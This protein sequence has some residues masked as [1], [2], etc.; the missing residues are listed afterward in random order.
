MSS[1]S[2]LLLNVH[3]NV[4]VL[5]MKLNY[6]EPKIYNGGLDK[7]QWSKL[8]KKKFY[9]DKGYQYASYGFTDILKNHNGLIRQ[10]MSRKGNCWDNAFAGSFFK[11]LNV[12]WV[13][14]HSYGLRS[15]AELSVFP[16][17][18]TWY[19]RSRMHSTLGHKTI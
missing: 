16:W 11:S 19:N 14:K 1:I 6:S 15:E 8:T 9:S 12:E 3:E 17:I 18:E 10:S 13:Y 2:V 4:N 5:R 7:T